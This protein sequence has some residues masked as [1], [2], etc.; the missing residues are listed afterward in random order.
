M[1]NE[2]ANAPITFKEFVKVM[3]NQVIVFYPKSM[4]K[5]QGKNDQVI[6]RDQ[7]FKFKELLILCSEAKNE[8]I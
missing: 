3:I 2:A 8:R 7:A 4:K 5:C 6:F 1:K